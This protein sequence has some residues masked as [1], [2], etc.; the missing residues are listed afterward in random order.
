MDT[1]G[2][3]VRADLTRHYGRC[4]AARLVRAVL[5]ERTFRVVLTLRLCQAV[6]A[7]RARPLLPLAVVAH[8]IASGSAAVDLPWRT[9]I[10]PGF[11]LF[12]GWGAVVNT[13]AVIGA[14]VSLFHGVTLGQGDRIGPDGSRTTGYPVIGDE[15]WIGP[16][17]VVVGGVT[18]G[19]GARVGAGAVVTRDVEPHTMV[20]GNP[21]VVVRT[22]VPA[23]V[24]NP[25][26]AGRPTVRP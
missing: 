14:D 21:A 26:G 2:A 13:G 6:A 16:H 15:V 20:A 8:R 23:D 5:L 25:A 18:V 12:H 22:D 24:L 17:A 1:L 9:R 11:R 7:G 10:G 4:S 19:R 3:V